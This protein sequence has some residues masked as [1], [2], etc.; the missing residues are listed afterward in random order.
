[1]TNWIFLDVFLPKYTMPELTVRVEFSVF[2][3]F[4][5]VTEVHNDKSTSERVNESGGYMR[6]L[7]RQAFRSKMGNIQIS[8]ACQSCSGSEMR[9]III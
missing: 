5:S 3:V 4:S 2:T 8:Y 6:P 1:M 7:T 9:L